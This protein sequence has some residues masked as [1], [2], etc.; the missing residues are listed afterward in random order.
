MHPTRLQEL[1][2]RVER[3]LQVDELHQ[4]VC[5][6]GQEFAMQTLGGTFCKF[7]DVA[8][9]ITLRLDTTTVSGFVLRL[10]DYSSS[11]CCCGDHGN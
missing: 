1:E 10:G 9:A 3:R 4:V 8:S 6:D 2:R 5:R 11:V 7:S